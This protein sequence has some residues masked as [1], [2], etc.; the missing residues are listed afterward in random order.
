M[1]EII[2]EIRP[3]ST[4]QDF[5]VFNAFMRDLLSRI[6]LLEAKVTELEEGTP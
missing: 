6:A 4:P 1:I 2:P 5:E 3:E